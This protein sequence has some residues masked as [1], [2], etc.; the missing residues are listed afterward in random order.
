MRAGQHF[1]SDANPIHFFGKFNHK[2]SLKSNPVF[3]SAGSVNGK[4]PNTRHYYSHSATGGVHAHARGRRGEMRVNG[5]IID[6]ND[7]AMAWKMRS[8][9]YS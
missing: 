9:S 8:P 1:D 7:P 6:D 2:L 5:R 4:Q 3:R